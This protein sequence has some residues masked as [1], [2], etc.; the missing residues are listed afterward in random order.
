MREVAPGWDKC[1]LAARYKEWMAGRERPKRPH[2]A[3]LGWV[4]KFTKGNPP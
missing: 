3:F 2:A 4:K 1:F